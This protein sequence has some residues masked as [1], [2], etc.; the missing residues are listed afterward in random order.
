MEA[1]LAALADPLRRELELW[2]A[3]GRQPR[4]WLRDDDAVAPGPALD[5]LLALTAAAGVPVTLAVIPQDSGEAL[6]ARLAARPEV[7]VAV[8]GW[9]HRGYRAPGAL[10]GGGEF[11]PERPAAE[12]LAEAARG[13]RKLAGLHGARALPVFVPPWNR[14][15]R[16]FA[17]RLAEVGYA[18]LSAW[19]DEAA[20]F[21]EI[22]AQVAVVNY[23]AGGAATAPAEQVAEQMLR[24]LRRCRETGRGAVGVLSHHLAHVQATE[25]LLAALIEV[26]QAA[27]CAWVGLAELLE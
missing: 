10:R 20:G 4:L 23:G 26:T 6:A 22:N 17:P 27:G 14:L 8:H 15:E 21:P 7:S 19:G 18:A 13:L 11:G 12:R 24:R 25:A 3:A 9:R 2:R 16:S 5:R 1:G